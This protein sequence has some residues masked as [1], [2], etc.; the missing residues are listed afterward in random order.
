MLLVVVTVA[1]EDELVLDVE[2]DDAAVEVELDSTEVSEL[3]RVSELVR[4]VRLVV[5]MVEPELLMPELV[6]VDDP[7]LVSLVLV[8]GELE[9]VVELT[10]AA[11]GRPGQKASRV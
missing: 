7:M 5:D 11:P 8:S 6:S 2:E 10:E 1:V 9:L 4:D 3:L